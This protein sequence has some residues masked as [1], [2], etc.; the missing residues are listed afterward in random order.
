MNVSIQH[1]RNIVGIAG[2]VSIVTGDGL[3]SFWL[4][5]SGWIRIRVF[6]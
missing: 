1:W 5:E 3:P 6:R 4:A 2:W